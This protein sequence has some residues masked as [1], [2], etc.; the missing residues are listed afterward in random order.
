[1][2]PRR[3]DVAIKGD[4]IVAVG[5]FPIADGARIIDV[6]SLIVAPG[7]I[8]LHTHSDEEI[9]KP[10][11]RLN[12]NYLTQGVTT[13]V[14]GNCGFGPI[15]VAKY[16]AALNAHGAGTNVI[17]LVP[18]GSLRQAVMGPDDRKPIEAELERMKTLVKRGLT[19]G[20]W[21]M[22]TG[23]IYVPGCYS[24]TAEL[25]DLA[26]IV[27]GSGGIYASHIRNEEEGLLES[28]DE[29]I[30]IGKSAGVP[31]HI[32]HLKANGRSNWGKAVIGA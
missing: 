7:F 4:R 30:A 27:A 28:I 16:F 6:S 23:L 9:I 26:R 13:V 2:P 3:G 15:D 14:T 18:H 8:D 19:A 25:S 5:T 20:A 10:E 11:T 22:S 32:S 31:V 12:L 29:A 1:M 21:G 17:H 24:S